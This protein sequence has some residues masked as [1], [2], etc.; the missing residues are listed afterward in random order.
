LTSAVSIVIPTIGNRREQLELTLSRLHGD[1]TVLEVLV[2]DDRREPRGILFAGKQPL[3]RVIL[4]GGVGP[5][6]SRQAGLEAAIG[7]VVLFLD[8]DVV[9][10]DQLATGHALH[11]RQPDRVVVGYMPVTLSSKCPEPLVS[12]LYRLEYERRVAGY[13]LHPDTI[14]SNLW[15][16]NVSLTRAAALKLGIASTRFIGRRH[17]DQEFG[18]RCQRAGMVGVFDRKLLAAHR[19]ERSVSE[20]LRDASAQGRERA[21][22]QS[23]HPDAQW[24]SLQ[25]ETRRSSDPH[26]RPLILSAARSVGPVRAPAIAGLQIARRVLLRRGARFARQHTDPPERAA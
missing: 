7:E 25:L 22:L 4:S 10:S 18:I 15:G 3:V 21:Q 12:T 14:L 11:H 20:F 13:E 16:G 23:L 8:D 2:V 17:E 6:P 5:N 26:A 19:Y 9:P 1:S 24:A